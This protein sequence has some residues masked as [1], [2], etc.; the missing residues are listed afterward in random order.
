MTDTPVAFY[1][2]RLHSFQKTLSPEEG[3]LV[4]KAT[5]ITHFVGF[6]QLVPE[7]REALLFITSSQ[8]FLFHHSF[9]PILDDFS[10]LTYV[11]HTSLEK[12][13]ETFQKTKIHKLWIQADTLT[14]EEYLFFQENLP[15][16]TL[17]MT[18]CESG[19][20]WQFRMIK[21]ALAQDY[22]A[23]AGHIIAQVFAEI[24]SFLREG[25][26]EKE[27]AGKI[28]GAMM[29]LGAEGP[30]FPTIV[31][32]GPSGALPHHQPTDTPLIAETSVLV[33]AGARFHGYRSDM[34]RTF[35]F[36]KKP[37]SQFQEIE[38]IVKEAY[39]RSV[40]L[41]ESRPQ[42][43]TAQNVD[44]AAREYIEKKGYGDEFIHST[45]HG[46]GLDIHEPPSVS[47]NNLTPLESGMTITVEPGIYLPGI[48]GYRYE[49]TL[50]L[51]PTGY[52]VLT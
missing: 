36:G 50:Q 19:F 6:P 35:W 1:T 43:L 32:F 15:Q 25:A 45:G 9:S 51:T 18:P 28:T 38:S 26:T 14:A 39:Q 49:N 24:P 17:E 21:D 47:W 52:T 16:N 23:K 48:L 37:S 13:L 30:A 41:L 34:T 42:D 10:A 20:F 7:E 31:A 46:V 40:H 12:V 33:D 44:H 5:D 29:E 22:Q 2:Q 27:V 11:P 4:S 8:A 3:Y